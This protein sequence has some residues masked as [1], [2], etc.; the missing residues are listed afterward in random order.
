MSQKKTAKPKTID[1]DA[2]HD[3][4]DKAGMTASE[5]LEWGLYAI[6]QTWNDAHTGY[7]PSDAANGL[8]E[9]REM[10]GTIPEQLIPSTPLADFAS[11]AGLAFSELNELALLAAIN[12][13]NSSEYPNKQP[14][15]LLEDDR[16]EMGPLMPHFQH[17]RVKVHPFMAALFSG[18]LRAVHGATFG[19]LCSDHVD[20]EHIFLEECLQRAFDQNSWGECT[21]DLISIESVIRHCPKL[22]NEAAAIR[23]LLEADRVLSDFCQAVKAN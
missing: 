22:Q 20:C 15:D 10:E 17:D 2:I 12:R 7:F 18:D 14:R 1:L 13:L 23:A 16:R 21:S 8:K 6:L 19:D 4:A 11:E 3:M 5:L 9:L